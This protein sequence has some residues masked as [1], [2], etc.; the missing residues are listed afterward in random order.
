MAPGA[1]CA[2]APCGMGDRW[3][4]IRRNPAFAGNCVRHAAAIV[5]PGSGVGAVSDMEVNV[6]GDALDPRALGSDDTNMELSRRRAAAMA[7]CLTKAGIIFAH[8]CGRIWQHA[9]DRFEPYR[10]G[11]DRKSTYRV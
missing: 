11:T 4:A 1:R 9:S 6:K 8:D 2:T 10:R 7:D 3:D 5:P